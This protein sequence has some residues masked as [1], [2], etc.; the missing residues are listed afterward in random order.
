MVKKVIIIIF[1][2]MF[3]IIGCTTKEKRI[4]T[5]ESQYTQ[6]DVAIVEKIAVREL[7]VG[8]TTD[9]VLAAIGKPWETVREGD[10]ERWAYA[11]LVTYGMGSVRP[12]FVYFV[13]FRDGKVLSFSGDRGKLALPIVR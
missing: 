6:W 13:H 12:K 2:T 4:Q 1:L 11:V 3:Y 9:M 7:E 5:I 10:E 8:M